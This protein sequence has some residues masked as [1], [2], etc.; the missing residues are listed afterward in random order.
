M[1]IVQHMLWKVV[2]DDGCYFLRRRRESN[3]T[4]KDASVRK[5]LDDLTTGQRPA[6]SWTEQGVISKS[7]RNSEF[8]KYQINWRHSFLV[9]VAAKGLFIHRV[10]I[11]CDHNKIFSRF[12][13]V[14]EENKCLLIIFILRLCENNKTKRKQTCFIGKRSD[15]LR[16]GSSNGEHMKHITTKQFQTTKLLQSGLEFFWHLESWDRTEG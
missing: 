7:K 4:E 1:L 15:G 6:P 10:E 9:V 11:C 2:R 5:D 16:T 14:E 3:L 13:D 8:M 12:F